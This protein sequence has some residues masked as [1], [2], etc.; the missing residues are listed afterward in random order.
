MENRGK[1]WTGDEE[2]LL[3]TPLEL[4]LEGFPGIHC[5]LRTKS[6]FVAAQSRGFVPQGCTGGWRSCSHSGKMGMLSHGAGGR[7]QSQV[8]PDKTRIWLGKHFQRGD[9][10]RAK[11]NGGFS[12]GW[13]GL[14]QI[15]TN[16]KMWMN[17]L[18]K[19]GEEKI[20]GTWEQN[21][22][23]KGK[24]LQVPEVTQDSQESPSLPN[25]CI[26]PE[27]LADSDAE[28]LFWDLRWALAASRVKSCLEKCWE[29]EGR[30]EGAV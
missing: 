22:S 28:G 25:P 10:N 1:E 9:V 7:S 18:G 21:S 16:D 26:T 17:P 5:P 23:R 6:R 30:R 13:G 8:S 4:Q 29:R 12:L 2:K 27:C 15:P 20:P 11:N 19:Q 14:A 24:V 3:G